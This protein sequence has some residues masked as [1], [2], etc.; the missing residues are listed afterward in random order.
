M[1]TATGKGAP[2]TKKKLNKKQEESLS[3]LAES[4]SNGLDKAE[5]IGELP[6]EEGEREL[7]ILYQKLEEA[8]MW[9]D[10]LLENLGFAP[11]DP[12]DDEDDDEDEPED[13]DEGSGAS[14]DESTDD[15]EG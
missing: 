1:T 3:G 5:S 10:R 12:E 7:A 14:D 13:D 9:L 11:A 4:I 2:V 8:E 6:T 15:D